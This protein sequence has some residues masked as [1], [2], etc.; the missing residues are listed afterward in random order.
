MVLDLATTA[1]T[2]WLAQQAVFS[3]GQRYWN[4]KRMSF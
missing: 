4:K 1:K 3:F 2:E